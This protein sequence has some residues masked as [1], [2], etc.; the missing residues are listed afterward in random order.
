MKTEVS[1]RTVVFAVVSVAVLGAIITAFVLQD[2]VRD[3]I[4]VPVFVRVQLVLLYVRSVPEDSLWLILVV[5]GAYIAYRAFRVQKAGPRAPRLPSAGRSGSS[6]ELLSWTIQ[7]QRNPYFR[8]RI[9]GVLAAQ[10][11]RAARVPPGRARTR[12]SLERAGITIPD[13]IDEYLDYDRTK[14]AGRI[15]FGFRKKNIDA[16]L[17]RLEHAVAAVEHEVGVHG[18]ENGRTDV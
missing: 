15:L 5:I 7:A 17:Q 11:C 12:E 4:V 10:L 16:E 18:T 2:F 8:K 13:Y 3:S 6:R 14:T 1:R 9:A